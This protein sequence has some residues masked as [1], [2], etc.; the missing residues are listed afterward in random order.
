MITETGD[1]L[2]RGEHIYFQCRFRA[3]KQSNAEYYAANAMRDWPGW[4]F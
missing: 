3:G 1:S 4:Y 2:S